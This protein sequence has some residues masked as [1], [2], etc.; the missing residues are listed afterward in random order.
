M[1]VAARATEA[2]LV[3]D[4]DL[5]AVRLICITVGLIGSAFAAAW[6]HRKEK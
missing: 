4:T 2:P 1:A 3:S 6:A 5:E